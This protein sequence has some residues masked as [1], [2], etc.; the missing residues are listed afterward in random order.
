MSLPVAACL[1]CRDTYFTL[2]DADADVCYKAITYDTILEMAR[3]PGR[4]AKHNAPV[5]IPSSYVEKDGRS[6]APQR[7]HGQFW[8]LTLDIDKGNLVAVDIQAAIK[9]VVGECQYLIYST[10]SASEENKK[11]RALVPLSAPILG[12]DFQETQEAFF[13]LLADFDARVEGDYALARPGQAVFLPNVPR[14]RRGETGAPKFYQH[15]VVDGALLELG[16]DHPIVV[17]REDVRAEQNRIVEEI[18][19][20]ADEQELKNEGSP[21]AA[22]NAAHTVGSLLEKY[23]YHRNRNSRSWRSPYQTSDSYATTDFDT[24]WVSHSQS[25]CKVGLGKSKVL[26]GKNKR[27]SVGQS[28][29]YCWGDAFDLYVHYEHHDDL[30]AAVAA[31]LA[32]QRMA[33]IPHLA[34][35]EM[36]SKLRANANN[37]VADAEDGPNDCLSAAATADS[38]ASN[39]KSEAY[40]TLLQPPRPETLDPDAHPDLSDDQLA[41][42][43]GHAGFDVDAVYVA[44][45]G[46]WLFWG[47][48]VWKADT[49]CFA[50]TLTRQFL[51]AKASQLLDWAQKRLREA[52][53]HDNRKVAAEKALAWAKKEAKRL[54]GKETVAAVLKLATSNPKSAASA[55]QFDADLFILATPTGV[56]ELRTGELREARRE[57]FVTKMTAIGPADQGAQPTL[58]LK[59]LDRIFD[60]D[61]DLIAF[62]QRAAGYA[63]TGSIKEHKLLFLYGTG[64]NGKSVFL[65]TLMGILSDYGR[66]A[67]AT[68][69][70][71]KAHEAHP[72]ELAGLQGARLVVG[73]EL[74]A[75]KTWNEAVI[76]DLTGGDKITARYM[77]QDF[78]DFTPQFTLMI[79]GNHQPALRGVDEAMRARLILVPFEVTIPEEERD[80]EL[81]TKLHQEWPQILRWCIDGAV[82]WHREGLNLPERVRAASKEYLEDEDLIGRYLE[83]RIVQDGCNKVS[84]R[85]IAMDFNRWA[86][87]QGLREWSQHAITKAIKE[88][89]RFRTYKSAGDRGFVGL[90]LRVTEMLE[91]LND[92][93]KGAGS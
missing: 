52:D 62:M 87:P 14:D 65:N 92:R 9:A 93:I 59:F 3:Q 26:E 36:R 11:W 61:A 23:R 57:D 28:H 10:A 66:R 6:H 43:L 8:Y 88:T 70:L 39:S 4:R 15:F 31:V 76:K 27:R 29:A 55:D 45:W 67:A 74:P 91:V 18:S 48:G 83:A 47:G 77:R 35:A 24:F 1:Y 86:I 73:S 60:G 41:I 51:R 20:E 68:V 32:Q 50:M 16:T 21:I 71:D 49:N 84:N 56:V 2:K 17:R 75:G 80:P 38:D 44:L 19:V 5:F 46:K 64:R 72:T 54:R 40:D 7:E 58:W 69:F 37:N 82:A 90:K 33:L 79:A 85:E 22:F 34:I 78:F 42:E 63:L 12:A 25:D 53:S 89:G 13:D 81:E 30:E